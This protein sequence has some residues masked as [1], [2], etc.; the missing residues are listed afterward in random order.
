M[1][2]I[3][4]ILITYSNIIFSNVVGEIAHLKNTNPNRVLF[5]G[6]SYFYYNDS[7]HNH[8][9]RMVEEQFPNKI[10]KL[11]FKSATIGGSKLSHHDIDH[12]IAHKNIGVSKP[13]ELVILQGGSSEPL[14]VESRMKFKQ[15]AKNLIKK[16]N[17]SG[18]DAALYMI[19][20]YVKPHEDYHPKMIDKIINLYTD[21]GNT[22]N[23][24]VLPV[25]IAFENAYKKRPNIKLHKDF[26]GTHPDLLGTYLSACVLFASIYK[27][28]P[29]GIDYSYFEK[30]NEKD[31]L[32]LQNIAHQTVEKFFNISL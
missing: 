31:K 4:L 2:L 13:F 21:S 12:L 29:I 6:N 7:L 1:K 8:V 19:H 11:E 10:D 17:D 27:T 22:T 5:V 16:I 9:R 24:L 15:D 25:G 26:D 20:A 14:T 30:I 18:A 28:S 3:F 23:T 32:F